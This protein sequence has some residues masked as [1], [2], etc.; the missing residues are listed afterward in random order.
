MAD[1]QA[2]SSDNHAKWFRFEIQHIFASEV[3]DRFSGLLSDAGIKEEMRGNKIALLS[4]STVVNLV[5]AAGGT[6]QSTLFAA[7]WSI[8]RHDS[9]ASG[10]NHPGYNLFL[11]NQLERIKNLGLPQADQNRAV[12]H[13]FKF[14]TQ[15]SQG[16]IK[17][18]GDVVAVM[19]SDGQE[20]VLKQAW[21]SY[22]FADYSNLS[23]L[24]KSSIDI[25]FGSADKSIVDANSNDN[26]DYRNERAHALKDS[27]LFDA[28]QI[29][30]ADFGLGGANKAKATTSASIGM[31]YNL[32]AKLGY[33]LDDPDKAGEATAAALDRVLGGALSFEAI[34][35][36]AIHIFNYM[37]ANAGSFLDSL[38]NLGPFVVDSIKQSAGKM[39]ASAA[40]HVSIG[41]IAEFINAAYDHIKVGAKT[42]DWSLFMGDIVKYG[43]GMIQSLLLVTGS[44]MA[45]FKIHPIA[46]AVVAAGW[47]AYGIVDSYTNAG[48]LLGKIVN[49]IK[50]K[51]VLASDEL[52]KLTDGLSDF[53]L[54]YYGVGAQIPG[55]IAP[56][57]KLYV[58]DD[59][60]PTKPAKLL[61]SDDDELIFGRNGAVIFAGGGDDQIHHNGYGVVYAGDGNDQILVYDTLASFKA[62]GG[63]GNDYILA[64]NGTGGEFYG[65]PGRDWF[66]VK[67]PGAKLYGDTVDGQA[68][69]SGGSDSDNFWWTPG[70]TIMDAGRTDVLKF[71]GVPLVSGTNDIP[72][73]AKGGLGLF[74]GTSGLGLYNSPLYFDNLM[75]FINYIFV[76]KDLYVANV[77]D[78]L[79]NLFT[80]ASFDQMGDG[81][82]I[83]GA[84]KV[85]NFERV[86]SAWGMV[87]P[88]LAPGSL[89]MKFKTANPFLAALALLPPTL[90]GLNMLLGMVDDVIALAEFTARFAKS[91]A[92]VA[93]ADPLI[94]DLDGDGI[95]TIA[96]DQSGIRFDQ[97]LDFFSEHSG[98]LSG[99]DGFLVLD[100]NH[101]GK[102]EDAS[103]MFGGIGQSGLAELATHDSNH[104]GKISVADIVWA[105]LQVWRD[106]DGDALTDAGELF[107]LDALGIADIG[108]TATAVN[109]TTPQGTRL[110]DKAYFSFV[111]GGVGKLYDAVF[112]TNN[113]DT[114][115][116]GESG[117]ASWLKDTHIDARGFGS[118]VDLSVAM[119]NDIHLG[120]VVASAS[121]VMTV[122]KLK[123][124]RAQAG[125]ALGLWGQVN[126]LTRELTPVRV[127]TIAGKDSL[128]DYGV[129]HEDATGGF[130][131]NASGAAIRNAGGT[132]I[133]RATLADVLQQSGFHLEQTFSPSDRG[134]PTQFRAPLAY[135][136]E[137]VAGRAVVLDV[138]SAADARPLSAG[139]EWRTEALGFNPY[140][141]VPVAAI[142][143]KFIDG[144]VVDYTV[145]VTDAAGSFY[146]WARNLDYAAEL[147]F[148]YGSARDFNLR[149]YEVDFNSLDEVGST[150]DS[151][152]RV[153]LLT[154]GQFHFATSLGGVNFRPEMLMKQANDNQRL[155]T[156]A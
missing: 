133:I 63:A 72:L 43:A 1:G 118:I 110:V 89:G 36:Q 42:G 37:G 79:L 104:D 64:K 84:M 151:H 134:Q 86:E 102:V 14:A 20:T 11:Q 71:F 13:L 103:E 112:E 113:V 153:E 47:A 94:L 120:E 76:G 38:S 88:F 137:V 115:Y 55:N 5:Q 124:L 138:A 69:G 2:N 85:K 66:F 101:N 9:R 126:E 129:Y 25:F 116:R 40:T 15:V 150:D 93:G 139:Q 149:N 49:D 17:I 50:D 156:A 18:D 30:F 10:G 21:D 109:S 73:I 144:K 54:A 145:E 114:R 34:K 7:G 6:I 16:K 53:I 154:P 155:R 100:S 128:A 108:L 121:A 48:E 56:F 80:G 82:S 117:S 60:D 62:Y 57:E 99:D 140:A 125:E 105:D 29:R 87:L 24:Q 68:A 107:T 136:V 74:G 135:L 111:S 83:R 122:P 119:S 22:K 45:A 35:Q 130:W 58:I 27:G 97:N 96:M 67:T 33:K 98:W 61:G 44:T 92:W 26:T 41:D 3:F 52:L 152:L 46:G 81:S 8:N 70:T 141:D 28:D 51:V 131:T 77:F 32:V 146:V 39:V 95:E 106:I 147:Q 4:D 78:G 23:I 148:Y 65:G 123:V 59:L 91:L 132:V 31:I 142:G 143:V 12:Q 19:G 90:G 75:I 127:L